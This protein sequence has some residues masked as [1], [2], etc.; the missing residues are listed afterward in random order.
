M[1]IFPTVECTYISSIHLT[2]FFSRM[3]RFEYST[4]TLVPGESYFMRCYNVKLYD[5]DNR[6]TF[7]NGELL[8]TTHRL[9]W[10][11]PGSNNY[12][13]LPLKYVVYIEEEKPSTFFVKSKRLNVFLM[14]PPNIRPPGPVSHSSFNFIKLSFKDKLPLDFVSSLNAVVQDKRWEN[15]ESQKPLVEAPKAPIRL[16]TGIVGIERSLEEKQKATNE[17]ISVAFQDLSKLMVMA[18]EM[19]NLSKSISNK[20]KEKQGDITD[21]ETIKFKSYLLSLGIEDP[22]TRDTF[23]SESQ[24]FTKLANEI[25]QIIEKPLGEVGGLMALTDVYCRVNRARG[26][27]LLSPEDFLNGCSMLSKLKLPVILR[28]FDS[29]VKVLQLASHSDEAVAFDTCELLNEN[30]FLTAEGLARII[31]ISVI[32]AKERLITTEKFGKACRDESIEGL[33]FYPNKFLEE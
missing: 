5:G 26:L 25:C 8:L 24:Y 31:G 19:V 12:L 3:D 30:T 29:G 9:L 2:M 28:V 11:V 18:K 15:V 4:S 21:D 13:S 10:A 14:E 23:T 6:T 16:R 22:V 33:R 20:I 32:L 27:E 1:G 7:E 17:S